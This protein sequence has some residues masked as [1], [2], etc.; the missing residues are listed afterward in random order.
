[1]LRDYALH[2]APY[3]LAGFM[4][5]GVGAAIGALALKHNWFGLA[6]ANASRHYT[7][8]FR[9]WYLLACATW[10]LLPDFDI[11]LPILTGRK[12]HNHHAYWTHAP[13]IVVPIACL[14]GALFGRCALGER[15]DGLRMAGVA[16]VCATW[17]FVHDTPPLSPGNGIMWLYPFS[18]AYFAPCMCRVPLVMSGIK[19]F[20]SHASPFTVWE[21]A[22]GTLGL[23]YALYNGTSRSSAWIAL[24]LFVINGV[25]LSAVLLWL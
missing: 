8:V 22:V 6:D 11:V 1:M 9:F 4:D 17:H 3:A 18:E 5:F 24:Y 20:F 2:L 23:T 7:Q 25:W 13:L 10:A 19:E 16:G 15:R 14:M 12:L 21:V